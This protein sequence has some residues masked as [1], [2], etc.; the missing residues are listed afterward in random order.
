MTAF[1]KTIRVNLSTQSSPRYNSDDSGHNI[2]ELE[3]RNNDTDSYDSSHTIQIQ[4]VPQNN[5]SNLGS[6]I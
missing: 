2:Q 4:E 6:G 5:H 3:P 1:G